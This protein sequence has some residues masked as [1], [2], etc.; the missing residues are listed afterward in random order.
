MI[1]DLKDKALDAAGV[2]RVLDG[3]SQARRDQN[4]V[5]FSSRRS[6]VFQLQ[7]K[8]P[9]NEAF[10][11]EIRPTCA[12]VRH[13]TRSAG[14]EEQFVAVLPSTGAEGRSSPQRGFGHRRQ[15]RRSRL[16]SDSRDNESRGRVER[17]PG[18]DIAEA[19]IALAEAAENPAARGDRVEVSG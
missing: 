17:W 2:V 3:S 8:E 4:V 14:G 6:T 12:P 18:D 19:L 16:R 10:L 13:L 7:P 1:P 5:A 11:A 9:G 15:L